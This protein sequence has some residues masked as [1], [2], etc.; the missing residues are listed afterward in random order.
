MT[1]TNKK[2]SLWGVGIAVLYG[3]FVIFILSFVIFSTTQNYVLVEDNYYQKSLSYQDKIDMLKNTEN[4]A[5]KPNLLL[6]KEN[7]ILTISFADSLA[8]LGIA[9]TAHFFR[10]SDKRADQMIPIS[11]DSNNQMTISTSRFLKG[12]WVLKLQWAS[13]NTSYYQEENL[14][15]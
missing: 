13:S 5:V 8:E 12:F 9:G 4:L 6:D 14:T 7:K 1:E 2:K 11:L 15:F 3:S 10:P